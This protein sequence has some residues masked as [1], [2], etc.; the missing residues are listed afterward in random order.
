MFEHYTE[1]NLITEEF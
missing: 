1:D